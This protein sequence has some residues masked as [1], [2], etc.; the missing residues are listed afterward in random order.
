M[1]SYNFLNATLVSALLL[2]PQIINVCRLLV[3]C[4]RSRAPTA[5]TRRPPCMLVDLLLCTIMLHATTSVR[6]PHASVLNRI[7]TPTQLTI[8]LFLEELSYKHHARIYMSAMPGHHSTCPSCRM[9]CCTQSDDRWP[10][11]CMTG[12]CYVTHCGWVTQIC[13]F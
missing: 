13:V 12:I 9:V 4:Y 11:G 8:T 6:E 3:T 5:V 2:S 7:V 10:P 1:G